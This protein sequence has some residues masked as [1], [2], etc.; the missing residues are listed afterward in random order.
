MK[1]LPPRHIISICLAVPNIA[2]YAR[3][4]HQKLSMPSLLIPP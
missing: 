2:S 1:W 4:A 3:L